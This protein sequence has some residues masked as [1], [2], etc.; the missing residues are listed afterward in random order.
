MIWL[1]QSFSTDLIPAEDTE[2]EDG[3]G[4]LTL[5]TWDGVVVAGVEEVEELKVDW[6]ID[7]AGKDVV[8]ETVDVDDTTEESG[9]LG[10][11]PGN[12]RMGSSVPLSAQS[13]W[14]SMDTNYES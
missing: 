8:P 3:V 7:W 11:C 6:E 4:V 9:R 5:V 13:L 1:K 2:D 14:S 12:V 10:S